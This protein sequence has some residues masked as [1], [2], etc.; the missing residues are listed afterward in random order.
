MRT[1]LASLALSLAA[2]GSRSPAAMAPAPAPA[3]AMAPRAPALTDAE[4][5]A[6]DAG[7]LRLFNDDAAVRA[8]GAATL[9]ELGPVARP[10]LKY[11]LDCVMHDDEVVA[12]ACAT[13]AVA[14]GPGAVPLLSEYAASASPR[15]AMARE[16]LDAIELV[17]ARTSAASP[18]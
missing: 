10:A 12:R 16:A 7:V 13:A 5:T 8:R 17:P 11:L 6:L 9:A 1:L 18:I 15:A 4:Q 2:C 14:I 3:A